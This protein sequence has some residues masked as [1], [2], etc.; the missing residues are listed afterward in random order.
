M[1]CPN[2]GPLSL[3]SLTFGN[4]W[5]NT[6][7]TQDSVFLVHLLCK[8]SAESIQQ[9]WKDRSQ[10][11]RQTDIYRN[12]KLSHHCHGEGKNCSYLLR[13][14]P[15]TYFSISGA[16]WTNSWCQNLNCGFLMSSMK[17]MRRPHGWG[18]LT[19]SR[20]SRTRV[21]CSWMASEFA[22]AKRYSRVQLK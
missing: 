19:I 20:S 8:I 6:T 18:L 10:M 17:V 7:K 12:S 2:S 22:S 13:F 11:D 5:G 21:I 4:P 9:V 14:Q 16:Q 3:L 1:R 15:I